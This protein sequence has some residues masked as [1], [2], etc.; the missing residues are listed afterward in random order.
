MCE[1]VEQAPGQK[2]SVNMKNSPNGLDGTGWM[3]ADARAA[4][5]TLARL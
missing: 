5:Q 2:K 1:A 4:L 3:R